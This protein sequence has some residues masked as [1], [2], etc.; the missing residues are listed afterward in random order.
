MAF[1]KASSPHGHRLLSLHPAAPASCLPSRASL[2]SLEGEHQPLFL[3]LVPGTLLRF[4][5]VT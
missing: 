2:R 1:E 3:L 5:E 4:D